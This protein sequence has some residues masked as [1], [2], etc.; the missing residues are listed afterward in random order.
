MGWGLSNPPKKQKLK[1]I[2]KKY[3]IIL[4]CCVYVKCKLEMQGEFVFYVFEKIRLEIKMQCEI[5]CDTSLKSS[6]HSK[7]EIGAW[8]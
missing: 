4:Y 7:F 8:K 3:N 1:H 6:D 5:K 2:K